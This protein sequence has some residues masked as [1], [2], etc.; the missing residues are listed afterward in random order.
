MGC[1]LTCSWFYVCLPTRLAAEASLSKEAGK[2]HGGRFNRCWSLIVVR[3]A[4][5]GDVKREDTKNT[6]RMRLK[7][8]I[9]ARCLHAGSTSCDVDP[10]CSQWESP[11]IKRLARFSS[12]YFHCKSVVYAR[13]RIVQIAFVF[14]PAISIIPR[15]CLVHSSPTPHD[16]AASYRRGFVRSQPNAFQMLAQHWPVISPRLN[17]GDCEAWFQRH[18]F[19]PVRYQYTIYRTVCLLADIPTF[20]NT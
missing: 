16:F 14:F 12:S 20:R 1:R 18:W 13:R 8:K 9:K 3:Q 19:F 4:P 7:Q 5:W 17:N 10:A 11:A 6:Q 2:D 15:G